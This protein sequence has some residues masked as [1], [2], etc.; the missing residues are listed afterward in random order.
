MSVMISYSGL[1][2]HSDCVIITLRVFT[3]YIA[4][5]VGVIL[6]I[7]SKREQSVHWISQAGKTWRH[8]C[9]MILHCVLHVSCMW[10]FKGAVCKKC[11]SNNH[12]MGEIPTTEEITPENHTLWHILM[13]LIMPIFIE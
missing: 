5:I 8:F 1:Q 11:I 10:C 13:Q 7:M 4:S 9:I 3:V 2:L 6:V 12:K